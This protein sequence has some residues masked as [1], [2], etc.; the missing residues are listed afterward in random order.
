MKHELEL[1]IWNK[2]GNVR[3][4]YTLDADADREGVIFLS[5]EE[6]EAL[7]ADLNQAITDAKEH[8]KEGEE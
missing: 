8:R 1:A 7:A 5:I 4:Q 3:V 2:R 6:A